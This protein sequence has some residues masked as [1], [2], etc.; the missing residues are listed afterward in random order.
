MLLIFAWQTKYRKIITSEENMIPFW[1]CALVV[2]GGF[3]VFNTALM[4]RYIQNSMELE[5]W[6]TIKN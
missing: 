6:S 3:Y 5:I 1:R 2:F 4:E